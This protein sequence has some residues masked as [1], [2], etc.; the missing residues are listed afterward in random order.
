ML[1]GNTLEHRGRVYVINGDI[2]LLSQTALK[3]L[4]IIP[5]KFSRIGEFLG[6]EQQGTFFYL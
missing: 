1:N 2:L 3:D 5:T 6:I 4:G